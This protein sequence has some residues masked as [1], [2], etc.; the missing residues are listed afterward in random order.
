MENQS[1][2]YGIDYGF[3]SEPGAPEYEERIA[4]C[5]NFLRESEQLK[6]DKV[7]HILNLDGKPLKT[8]ESLNFEKEYKRRQKEYLK[9]VTEDN[10]F[11]KAALNF[12]ATS[13]LDN[14]ENK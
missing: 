2:D 13:F 6:S 10:S 9:F 14:K 12:E 11:I 3:Y 5:S 7:Q 1:K 4:A 8:Q